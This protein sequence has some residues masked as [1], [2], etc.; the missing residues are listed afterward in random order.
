MSAII[1]QAMQRAQ[2]GT[3]G[4]AEPAAP[5]TIEPVAQSAPLSV[6][7][8]REDGAD[9]ARWDAFVQACPEAT[10]FHRAGWQRVIEEAFGH[11]TWFLLAER[12]GQIEGVLP[13]AQIKSRLFGHSLI[14]L[15]FC[16]Y[17][18]VAAGTG[19]ARTALDTEALQ[20]ARSLNVGHLEY[21][22][23]APAHP[24]DPAWLGK[25]LYVTF[26]KEI[27]GDDEANMNAIPRKQRAMVRKGIKLGLT[28][29]VDEHVDRFFTAYASS[30]HRLGTPVFSKKYFRLLKEEF[31]D[32]CEVRVIV[33]GEGTEKRLIAA[34]LSFF[35]R[36]EVLPYYGGGM[37]V[38]RDVAGNDF[39]YWNL[40]Q[41]SAA[42]GYR[43]FDFG[44]SK[45]GTGA[46]DF[47][48]NWGFVAQ[49][50]PYEY[51]LIVSQDLPD[52][53]PLN[54]KYRLFIKLWQ[55]LPLPLANALGPYIVKDLG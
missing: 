52:V 55:K 32:D 14:A 4:P 21:R 36:D 42:K 29:E 47:K 50:L 44:R 39:M 53:N 45:R 15:P 8:L 20:L 13:L 46:Y 3:A 9:R 51:R 37:P 54:P 26:R 19:E 1:E 22:N 7:L 5:Q 43:L 27:S 35:F 34:V 40:M 31:C 6:R 12:D 48:K 23:Y 2:A 30:V 11:R 49:P 33:Q 25:D 16:V 41:A 38:A 28:G 18:G 17:G 24:N 10:F